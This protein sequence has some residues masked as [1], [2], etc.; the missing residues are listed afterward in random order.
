MLQEVNV[1]TLAWV[2]NLQVINSSPTPWTNS[3][4]LFCTSWRRYRIKWA[5]KN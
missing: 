1:H 3:L 2:A 5:R 4:S